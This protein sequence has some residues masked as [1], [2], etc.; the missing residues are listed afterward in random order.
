MTYRQQ[1]Q[2][3]VDEVEKIYDMA[4]GLRDVAEGKEK[5]V[6]NELRSLQ[7]RASDILRKLDDGLSDARAGMNC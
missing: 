5:E 6:F 1:I 2:K 4:G 7:R 3:Q